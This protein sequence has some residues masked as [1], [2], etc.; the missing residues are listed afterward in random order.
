VFRFRDFGFDFW[1]RGFIQFKAY[2]I[3][4][5]AGHTGRGQGKS[6]WSSFLGESAVI[7]GES[8]GEKR[9]SGNWNR[10][11]NEENA[12]PKSGDTVKKKIVQEGNV[13]GV[14]N[15]IPRS[16]ALARRPAVVPPQTG[17]GRA[18]RRIRYGRPV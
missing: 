12:F 2:T 9:L 10:F 7:L 6:I 8:V 1:G 5:G 11:E 18:R 13:A 4:P 15:V 14:L 16:A 3:Y 17:D